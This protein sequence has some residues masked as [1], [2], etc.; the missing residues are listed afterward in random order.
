MTTGFNHMEAIG[1]LS[2]RANMKWVQENREEKSEMASTDN[3]FKEFYG[4]AKGIWSQERVFLG[5]G[6]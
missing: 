2:K 3:S 5:W 1:N 6:R 4:K